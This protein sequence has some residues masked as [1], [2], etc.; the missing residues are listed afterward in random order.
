MTAPD[1]IY[2]ALFETD[3]TDAGT[4]TEV[5]GTG[6]GY[7]RKAITF[8]APTTPGVFTNSADILYQ[9][10]P[11]TTVTHWAIYDASTGGNLLYH[12]AWSSSQTYPAGEAALVSA[13]SL[14]ITHD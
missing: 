14:T 5:D 4:G 2:L 1:P 9:D 3:P 10:M 6:N 11:A 8:D 13:G 7:E 12:D